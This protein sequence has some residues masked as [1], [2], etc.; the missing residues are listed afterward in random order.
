MTGAEEAIRRWSFT[1][2]S[3]GPFSFRRRGV[4][5]YENNPAVFCEHIADVVVAL[6]I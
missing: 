3:P 2:S 5:R 1:N 6:S 4:L